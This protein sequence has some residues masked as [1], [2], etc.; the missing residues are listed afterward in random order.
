MIM[1]QPMSDQELAVYALRE[2]QLI[3]A[4]YVEPGPRNSEKTIQ[5]LMDVLDRNDVVE[6]VD[7]LEDATGLRML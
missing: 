5:Q 6:A 7:R 2:A 1:S 4:T 3:L